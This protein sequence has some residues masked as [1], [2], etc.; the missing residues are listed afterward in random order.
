MGAFLETISASTGLPVETV[1]SSFKLIMLSPKNIYV[2]GTVKISSYG[3]EEISLKVKGGFIII[4][5]EDLKIKEYNQSDVY[6][7]GKIK[8]INFA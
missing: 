8:A 6:I 1:M 7:M 2:E 5:G 3:K 4:S